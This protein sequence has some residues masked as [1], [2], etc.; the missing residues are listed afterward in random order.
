MT[1]AGNVIIS[2][3]GLVFVLLLSFNSFAATDGFYR[4]SRSETAS[5]D[6]ADG[7]LTAVATADYDYAH[8]DEATVSMLFPGR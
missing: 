6:G 3:V 5:W 4:L 1:R 8:G 2:L 7:D